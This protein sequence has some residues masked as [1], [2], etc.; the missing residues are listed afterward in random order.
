M[1]IIT[2]TLSGIAAGTIIIS[3]SKK[4]FYE[5]AAIVLCGGIGGAFPDIDA[6]SLWSKFDRTFGKILGLDHSGYEI[7][8]SKFWYSHHAFF[9]SLFAG[10]LFALII[11]AF[12]SLFR[13]ET[14]FFAFI[15]TYW[16]VAIAFITGYLMH[17]LGD[18]PT[19]SS[20]WGG[21][22]FFW[23]SQSYIG[24]FGKIWWWNNYDIF[25]IILGCIFLNAL[26]YITVLFV[27]L[28]SKLISVGLGLCCFIFIL[29]QINNRPVQFN[30]S[31]HTNRF[32]KNEELSKQV[33]QD[34]LGIKLYKVMAK[35][36]HKIPINF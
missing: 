13:K 9:H 31:A 4:G 12:L 20:V 14:S 21:V 36:D 19:P 33:Q 35:I 5:K 17:L 25:L 34:I 26:L 23:P 10:F 16:L 27:K 22:N 24:G 11:M 8:F 18:M 7:Y 32:A 29:V 2:H 3:F 6:M 30:Y 28:N 15:K 1:D